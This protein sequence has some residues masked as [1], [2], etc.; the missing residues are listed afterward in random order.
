MYF[1][2]LLIENLEHH[3]SSTAT[4]FTTLTPLMDF[5]SLIPSMY[6]VKRF[7]IKNMYCFSATCCVI[8]TYL[9]SILGYAE[10]YSV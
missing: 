10:V 9:F 7:G 4:L 6:L 3:S 8:C 2:Y 1:I 5:C